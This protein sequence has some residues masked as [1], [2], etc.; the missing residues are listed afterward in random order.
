M[1]KITATAVPTAQRVS[2]LPMLFGPKLMMR[3][4]AMLYDYA[5]Q[6]APD[7]YQRGHWEFY[8]LSNGSG[9]AAPANP[10]LFRLQ[11]TTNDYDGEM[12]ADAAGIV[13]TLFALNTLMWEASGKDEALTEKLI[14][15]WDKL[16]DYV[17][18]HPEARSIYRAID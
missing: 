1:P 17:A 4:E 7:S 16:R 8:T 14:E 9:F 5:Q 2:F 12:T 11:V 10:A 13:F 3:G 15:H 18:T 6:L